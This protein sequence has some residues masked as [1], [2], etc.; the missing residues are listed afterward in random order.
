[1]RYLER[2]GRKAAWL[3]VLTALLVLAAGVALAGAY[4]F[5]GITNDATNMR[6]TPNSSQANVIVRIPEGDA[7]TVLGTAGNFFK[8]EYDGRTG[9]VFQKYVERS[10]AANVG[11]SQASD[12]LTAPGYPYETVALDDVNL[13]KERSTESKRLASIPASAVVTVKGIQG[14]WA[15]VSYNGQDGW[16]QKKYLQLLDIVAVTATP[17]PAP[18]MQPGED[19][20]SYQVLQ[21]GADGDQVMALQE[22]LVE[23]KFLTGI[24]DGVYS[25]ATAQAVMAFQRVNE[26]PITGIADANMQAFLFNGKPKN[27]SGVKTEV[28]TLPALSG[29]TVN[30]GDKG[31]IVRTIQSKLAALGLYTGG[32]TGTYDNATVKAVKA[33]QKE[34][35]IKQ[36]GICG[37]NTQD[38]LLG[39]AAVTATP[40]PAY[41]PTPTPLPTFNIPRDTVRKG[42]RN[43]DAKLVQE[44]L[45]ELGYLAEAADGNFGTAS[46][47]ALKSFQRRNNLEDDGVA[48]SGTYAV[49]FSHLAVPAYYAITPAPALPQAPTATPVVTP[50]MPPITKDNVVVVKEGVSG[51]AVL[52]LQ[53]RLTELGYY[54]SPLDGKCKADDVAAIRAFQ[55]ANGLD[56]DGVAGYA[57]QVALYS[58]TAVMDNGLMA[59]SAINT[60]TTLKKGMYGAAVKDLQ[61]RLITLGYLKDEAD[62][63]FGTNTA[64]AVYNF[65]RNNGLVRDG[66]AGPKTLAAI[67]SATAVRPTAAPTVKPTA[68]RAPATIQTALTLRQGDVNSSVKQMQE[69]L[70]TLG[71]LNGKADGNFGAQTYRALKEFQRK[72]ALDA[73]G[74][75]G[76]QTIAALNSVNAIG[77]VINGSNT[78][79]NIQAPAVTTAPD[80]SLGLGTTVRVTAANVVYEY[81]YS[82][83]RAACRKYPYATVYDYQTGISWQVHMFSYGKH[84]EA[85]PLTANDTHKME[86]ACG[87][88]VWTPRPVWVI[89]AD[90]TIRMATTHSVPHE[91]QHIRDNDF[92]GH[93]CIHFPRTDAQVTAIGP[94]ATKHQRAVEQGW[95]ETQAMAGK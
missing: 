13:R 76:K 91:V 61:L 85:E 64:E 59:G 55:R 65:Q 22:A 17:I 42:T 18:T 68:T 52:R 30:S 53:Y 49:L 86:Q 40:A 67:Y 16:C 26:Y 74:I 48:G 63:N 73:D 5:T 39:V 31:L 29:I 35:G 6:R 36:D 82:E 44:R 90:G 72:N 14:N 23:L 71:Y 32:I 66:K 84:A 24:A 7:V 80:A 11:G 33:F 54:Q 88:N 1:M 50:A 37:G 58:A 93:T 43:A 81:W 87:G 8:I 3:A 27:A 56:V 75:A 45:I 20:T 47:A 46:V 69:R 21:S 77:S 60:D 2:M 10:T 79:Q 9:Y 94:Y 62:G 57:T 12:A 95:A 4:P 34:N 83:V 28:R 70:I 38:L 25:A 78:N 19:A 41:T 92:E 15:S 89:F 51:D